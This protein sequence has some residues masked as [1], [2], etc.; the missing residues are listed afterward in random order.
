MKVSE[1]MM[2]ANEYL[3][4]NPISF[5]NI[6]N[7]FSLAVKIDHSLIL[8]PIDLFERYKKFFDDL[9]TKN[10]NE[11]SELEENVRVIIAY[12]NLKNQNEVSRLDFF[13]KSIDKYPMNKYLHIFSGCCNAF[14]GKYEKAIKNFEDALRIDPSDFDIIYNKAACLRIIG[15]DKQIKAYQEYLNLAPSDHR[16]VPESYFA[17]SLYYF[18]KETQLDKAEEL[19]LKGLELEKEQ[20]PFYMP[21]KSNCKEILERT[22][23]KSNTKYLFNLFGGIS[24]TQTDLPQKVTNTFDDSSK[25]KLSKNRK[26]NILDHRNC[27]SQMLSQ[28]QKKIFVKILN[29]A[30]AKLSKNPTNLNRKLNQIY[31][32]EINTKKDHF[33]NNS[34]IKVLIIEEPNTFFP[35]LQFYVIDEKQFLFKVSVYNLKKTSEFKVGCEIN[36]E[37]PYMRL[38]NDGSSMIRVDDT[39]KIKIVKTHEICR[40]CS[41]SLSDSTILCSICNY[42]KYCSYECKSS[43]SKE[44]KHSLICGYLLEKSKHENF[45]FKNYLNMNYF[46]KKNFIIAIIILLIGIRMFNYDY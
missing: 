44:L 23:I 9:L 29:T 34:F 41:K 6:I 2:E 22:Y 24:K 39:N 17:M 10:K 35:S 3:T 43:D 45:F 19:Y 28:S 30:P 14:A 20:L 4:S 15:S 5:E 8:L 12:L 37:E 33:L 31:F 16:K 11:K 26:E 25:F 7:S 13:K 38:A 21:Y 18:F 32:N 1:L 27:I 36:I 40:F 42:A 46:S